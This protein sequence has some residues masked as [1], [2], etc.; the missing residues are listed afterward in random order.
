MEGDSSCLYLLYIKIGLIESTKAGSMKAITSMN[1]CIY[2]EVIRATTP[3]PLL[4]EV[5]P[6][7]LYFV[8]QPQC[9][10]KNVPPGRRRQASLGFGSS[11]TG[12][13]HQHVVG[14]G[15]TRLFHND[16]DFA[17]AD[18]MCQKELA[19]CAHPLGYNDNKM[20]YSTT[21]NALPISNVYV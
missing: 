21:K 1:V 12:E 2:L 3:F 8:D 5:W 6:I 16:W 11:L 10:K 9:E 17:F 19:S 20:H 14:S 15:R 4:R 18:H 13:Q 7:F